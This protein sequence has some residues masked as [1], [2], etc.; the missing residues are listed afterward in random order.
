M[1][2]PSA[3]PVPRLDGAICSVLYEPREPTSLGSDRTEGA[4]LVVGATW[5]GNERCGAGKPCPCDLSNFDRT[6]GLL[7]TVSTSAPRICEGT[8]AT[9]SLLF[10][11][12][13][14]EWVVIGAA[15]VQRIIHQA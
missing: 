15:P 1:C 8:S 7:C 6:V 5:P 9:L 10:V 11:C 12:K 4:E 13:A 14:L 3:M 2:R